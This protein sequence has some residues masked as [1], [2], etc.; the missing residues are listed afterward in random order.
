MEIYKGTKKVHSVTVNVFVRSIQ[1]GRS[2]GKF[3]WSGEPTCLS[4][5]GAL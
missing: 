5:R 3:D 1:L 4:F 2:S